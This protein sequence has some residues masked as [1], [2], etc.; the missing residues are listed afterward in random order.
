MSPSAGIKSGSA[1]R[2]SDWEEDIRVVHRNAAMT[3][4]SGVQPV[5]YRANTNVLRNVGTHILQD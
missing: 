4:P 5:L 1:R 2:C 3:A